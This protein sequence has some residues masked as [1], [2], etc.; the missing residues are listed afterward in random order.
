MAFAKK[1]VCGVGVND[2]S[3]AVNPLING[4]QVMCWI[5]KKWKSMIHRCYDS[6][7][8]ARQPAYIGCSVCEEWLTFSNFKLWMEAQDWQGKELDK[9][10][11]TAG[12]KIYSPETCVFVDGNLNK[13]TE[14]SLASRGEH[15]L[16]VDLHK[17]SGKF[18][19]RCSNPFTNKIDHLGLFTNQEQAHNTWRKRKHELACQL[20]DLQ[21]DPRVAKALRLRYLPA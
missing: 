7:I 4:K 2:A 17:K 5:Y 20:A 1:L 12:S 14:S 16:G 10:I 18:R 6:K 19:A 11:L 15:P 21:T 3:Y 8:Q 9:D 13:F